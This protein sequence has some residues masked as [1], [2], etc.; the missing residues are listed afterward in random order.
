MASGSVSFNTNKK[1]KKSGEDFTVDK[2]ARSNKGAGTYPNYINTKSKSGH[3]ITMDDSEGNETL[4]IQHR[5]GSA[6]QFKPDGGLLMTTH[7]GKYEVVFGEDRITISGAQDITV[8]GDASMR[9]YGDYNTTVHG[10]YNM[11]VMGDFNVTSKNHNRLIRGNIDTIAQN[12]TKKLAGSSSGTYLG[13]YARSAEESVSVISRGSNGYFGAGSGVSI[14]KADDQS[15]GDMTVRNRKG[16]TVHKNDDGKRAVSVES[17]NKKVYTVADEGKFSV[18]ADDRVNVKTDK[19]MMLDATNDVGVTGKNVS[20][21]AS[22]GNMELKATENMKVKGQNAFVKADQAAG[23][24]GQQTH[25]GGLNGT[26]H[27]VG[28]TTHVEGQGALNLNGGIG[29]AFS[30]FGQLNFDFGQIMDMLPMPNMSSAG[31]QPTETEPDA[32]NWT[33]RLA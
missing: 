32:T 1:R 29:A 27:V 33:S 23:L 4:T 8:K 26:T 25:V 22:G 7:N 10:D 31:A 19:E 6:I 5:S 28:S 12:E 30:D 3:Q 14:E 2:D 16:T 24:E 9:V 18:K 17:N 11:T 21:S 20:V 13:G 15:D